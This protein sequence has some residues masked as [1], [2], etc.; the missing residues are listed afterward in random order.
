MISY[1]LIGLSLIIV[2]WLI[3]LFAKNVRRVSR[4]FVGVYV[5]GVAVLVYDGFSSGM[6]DLAIANLVSLVVAL[7][8]FVKII[9]R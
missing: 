9:R 7:L 6:R 2:A 3:Q 8:V 5:F 4:M 1:S